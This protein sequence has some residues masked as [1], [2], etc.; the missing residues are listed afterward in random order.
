MKILTLEKFRL[1]GISLSTLEY[2]TVWWR[3]FHAPVSS[4]WPNALT[5]FELLF[6]FPSSN[7]IVEWA[8]S[9]MNVI[10]AKK[11]YLV[12]NEA[13]NDLLTIASAQVP[14]KEFCP[15]DAIDLW[16]KDKLHRPN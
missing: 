10:K 16:W 1:Y 7:G 9:Q 13:L 4:E 12:S 11:R 15:D 6:S 5:L 14:L 2:Q 3:I 8:F